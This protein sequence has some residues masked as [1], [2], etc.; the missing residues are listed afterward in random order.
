MFYRYEINPSPTISENATFHEISGAELDL[1][2]YQDSEAYKKRYRLTA[3]DRCNIDYTRPHDSK[4]WQM[5][6][7]ECQNKGIG[8]AF[9]MKNE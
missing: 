2:V 4:Q 6:P 9:S 5:F 7:I 1:N 3:G 8:W